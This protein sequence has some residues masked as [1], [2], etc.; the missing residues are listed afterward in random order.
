MG[1]GG[2]R[3]HDWMSGGRTDPGGL[4]QRRRALELSWSGL[5]NRMDEKLSHT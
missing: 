4:P 3:L 2:Q 5:A 1:E